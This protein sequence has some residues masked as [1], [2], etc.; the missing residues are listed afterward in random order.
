M[1]FHFQPWIISSSTDFGFEP[2]FLA[3]LL[4]YLVYL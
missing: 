4:W 3:L 2:L 1:F